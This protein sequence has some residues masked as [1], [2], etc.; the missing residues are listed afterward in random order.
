MNGRHY[1]TA[2][3][4]SN[5]GGQDR[6]TPCGETEVTFTTSTIT[7]T[8]ARSGEPGGQGVASS[9]LAVP[10]GKQQVRGM[11]TALGDHASDH[12]SVRRDVSLR[13]LRVRIGGRRCLRV[14]A[15]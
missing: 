10:T 12:L 7:Y 4:D 3:P 6:T 1:M 13:Q 15:R 11:I 9:N 5:L 2:T 8:G 14:G